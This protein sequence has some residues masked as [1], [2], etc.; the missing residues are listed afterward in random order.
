MLPLFKEFLVNKL[1][2]SEKDRILL[3]VSGGADSVAM[4]HLFSQTNFHLGIAHCNF[5]LRGEESDQDEE[6]VNK[7]AKEYKLPWFRVDFNTTAYASEHGI[8][9]EMAARELRYTWFE[10][11]RSENNYHYIATA[12]H[13]DDLIETFFINLTR[14]TGIRGLTGFRPKKE[15]LIRPMLFANREAIMEYVLREKL[16][17]REDSSNS[18]VKIIRNKFRHQILPAFLEINPA[19]R[20]N[21]LESIDNLHDAEILM[22]T[23]VIK[24]RADLVRKKG[25]NLIINIDKLKE[26]R[27]IHPY[28]FELLQPF[29]FNTDQIRDIENALGASPGKLFCSQE[30]QLNKDRNTLIISPLVQKKNHSS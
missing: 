7:L 10:K 6:L 25:Q 11:I 9:I 23:E 28:L 30:Y 12:H 27:T 2:I 3:T 21:I 22:N 17:Y 14:G 4:L 29:G 1:K 24:A 8:S 15:K 26:Y 18:D 13:Q 20:Q 19:F 5:H 16:E